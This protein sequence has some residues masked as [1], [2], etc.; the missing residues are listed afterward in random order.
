MPKLTGAE[1]AGE[2]L[3]I[4]PGC[5]V[6]VCSGYSDVFGAEQARAL[7]IAA[8][9]AKPLTVHGLAQAIRSVLG[10]DEPD[11]DG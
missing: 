1:L 10:P 4:R 2:V 11:G 6:I 7:G 9:V 5:P 3:S 8:Y